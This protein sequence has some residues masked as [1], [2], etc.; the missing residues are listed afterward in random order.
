MQ[1]GNQQVKALAK[2]AK[3]LKNPNGQQVF[4][5]FGWAGTGKTTLAKHFA[6]GAG[7]VA[8]GAFTGKAALVLRQKGCESAC[9][10]HSMIYLPNPPSEETVA[11][12]RRQLVYLKE[13][14]LAEG[15][16]R[17]EIMSH[18][19]VVFMQEQISNENEKNSQ[20]Y[21]TLNRDAEIG[22]MDLIIIDEVTMVD[23]QMGKDLASFNV[24][25][26][27]LG[28]PGQL[29]PVGKGGYFTGEDPDVLLT[30][31]HRQAA[32]SPIIRLAT[33]VR[34]GN[35]LTLGKF[36]NSEV[37][38]K[39][40]LR[41]RS[42]EATQAGIVLVG[43]N[44]TRR[45]TNKRLRSLE[46]VEDQYPVE[47]DQLVCLRNNNKTG[48]LNGGL[49]TVDKVD[50]DSDDTRRYMS[51]SSMDEPLRV[52]VTALSMIFRGED[53]RKVDP[54]TIMGADQFDFGRALTV[55][56]AQG[57]QWADGLLIDESQCFR[58]ASKKHLYTGITRFAE[59][60]TVA[61]G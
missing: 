49:W 58:G 44:A 7:R 57:S 16:S 3:W 53:H 18:R 21:F 46:G 56:K 29:P 27:V 47:G 31:V 30:E 51:L 10:I 19:R 39:A 42:F 48:L 23:D 34:K 13:E 60:V 52:D 25:I 6:E 54:F 37:I 22:S 4:R 40:E 8:F 24:P 12:I 1:W 14:L 28:D 50:E 55:N 20:P 45:N 41:N 2:V 15:M 36:G 43:R 33:M 35:P 59:T 11:E 5:L 26:L 32:D 38:T 61:V 17:D 9:T